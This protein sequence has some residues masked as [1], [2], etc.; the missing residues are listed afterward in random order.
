[1]RAP[2]GSARSW[3][4]KPLKGP[5]AFDFQRFG[6]DGLEPRHR[7]P[8]G[9]MFPLNLVANL[10]RSFEFGHGDVHVLKQCDS[11]KPQGRNEIRFA[12]SIRAD[13]EIE[14]AKR[15]WCCVRT[16]ALKILDFQFSDH[17]VASIPN[18]KVIVNAS[19][20]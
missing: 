6:P 5:L 18:L 10:A 11:Q 3:S 4:S 15:K 19:A 17:G 9:L 14:G 12:G 16:E 7:A 13:D 2:I 8:S 1:M 20:A